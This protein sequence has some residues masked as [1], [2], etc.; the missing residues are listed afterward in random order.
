VTPLWLQ[1][2]PYAHAGI[3]AATAL[4]GVLNAALLWRR[5]RREGLYAPERGWGSWLGRI[6]VALLAMA[7][8]VLLVRGWVGEWTVLHGPAR[9]LWLL[10]AVGA[11]AGAYGAML[12]MLGL[13]PRHLRH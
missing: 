4:A 11:G 6:A 1:Q 2:V 7:G 12:V 9:W 5:L 8:T 13:R 10:V 3:A